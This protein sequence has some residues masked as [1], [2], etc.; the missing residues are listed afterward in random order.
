MAPLHISHCQHTALVAPSI[1]AQ[2]SFSRERTYLAVQYGNGSLCS[3][4]HFLSKGIIFVSQKPESCSGHCQPVL[5][6][7][8]LETELSLSNVCLNFNS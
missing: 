5:A 6:S 1:L 3:N 7:A 4:L 2:S 8:S